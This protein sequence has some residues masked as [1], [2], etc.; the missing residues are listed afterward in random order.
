MVFFLTPTELEAK[1]A[2][3]IGEP[4]RL[5]GQVKPGS[6]D[7]NADTNELRFVMVEGDV[8]ID[9][10]STGAPPS[11]FGEGQ[12][13]VLE[14]TY[15]DDHVFRATNLMVKHSNEYAPPE[16]GEDPRDTYRSLL[17]GS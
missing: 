1:G 10:E 9:V 2:E 16:H 4:L 13:V 12:G 14:G 3:I 7:W 6:V 8:G 5:G 11:M 15:G 17:E